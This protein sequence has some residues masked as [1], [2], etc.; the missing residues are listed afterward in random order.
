MTTED[1]KNVGWQNNP[2]DCPA[3][4]EDEHGY[5]PCWIDTGNSICFLD[6]TFAPRAK[7][8]GASKREASE[9]HCHDEVT[10]SEL[11]LS[12]FS[13]KILPPAALRACL[14]P[15][16]IRLYHFGLTLSPGIVDRARAFF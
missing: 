7:I 15:G 11:T 10:L 4:A 8:F 6:V 16:N 12:R 3:Q 2:S 1:P 9:Q 14:L 13:M 5:T